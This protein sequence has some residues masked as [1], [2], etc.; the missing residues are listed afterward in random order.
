MLGFSIPKILLLIFIICLIWYGFKILERGSKNKLKKEE[1]S[2]KESSSKFT[3]DKVQDLQKCTNCG[4]YFMP[5]ASCT[6][7]DSQK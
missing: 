2:K 5:G 7:C 6:E 4:N 3:Q 1:G